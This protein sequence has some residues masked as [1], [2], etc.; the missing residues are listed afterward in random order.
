MTM[1]ISQHMSVLRLVP[2][3]LSS[4]RRLP[5]AVYGELVDII[6]SNLRPTIII[7]V[8][9]ACVGT[10]YAI[11]SRD[12]TVI[13]LTVVGALITLYR[14]VS[15][16]AFHRRKVLVQTV[17]V[18]RKWERYYAL[19]SHVFAASLGLLNA[20]AMSFGDP[21]Y[22]ML[23]T[24]LVFGYG[25]G[26]VSRVS[27]RPIICFTSLLLSA[28]PTALGFGVYIIAATDDFSLAAYLMQAA[29][30]LGFVLAGVET[31]DT[32]YRTSLQQIESKHDSII[33]AGRDALTGLPNRTLLQG[34][35]QQE[36]SRLSERHD[37]LACHFLDLDLFKDVNDKL[38]H[39]AGDAVL[40]MMAE[41]LTA[42]LRIGDT[43]A[44]LGGDEFVVLQTGV[45]A[46]D[47]AQLFGL[48]IIRAVSAPYV[49][50]GKEIK[51]GASIGVALAPRDGVDPQQLRRCADEALYRAKR[52]GG[53]KVVIYSG[54]EAG[55][56]SV[57]A[58]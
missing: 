11:K 42:M 12:G 41:R 1:S 57:S 14:I 27:A 45:R 23:A 18:T 13:G 39:E 4:S 38:G 15:F 19:G 25:C 17:E 6:Y 9:M 58:A 43:A 54:D 50:E 36:I 47:D 20:R 55:G 16:R 34:R 35:L 24:C 56:S 31:V 10:L 40:Q 32:V 3:L 7:G 49:Y 44:R 5:D 28:V 2:S 33:L 8:A 37:M 51:I 52:E 22:A 48:R 29:L 46:P 21:V 26:L 53:G 30:V